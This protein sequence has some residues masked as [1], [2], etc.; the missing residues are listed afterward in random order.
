MVESDVGKPSYA[1]G[2]ARLDYRFDDATSASLHVL[3]A[4]DRS[5]LR[6]GEDVES[7]NADYRNGY[8]WGT[9]D[10]EWT[11]ALRSTLLLSYS[12][13]A[14]R[15]TGAV[16][17][18]GRRTGFVDDDRD[19]H[20]F[21][22]K[23]D[24]SWTGTRWF[25]R[26]GL[27]FRS[28]SARYRYASEV[29]FAPD[30]PFPGDPGGT[31]TR[32]L[33]PAPDGEHVAAYATSRLRVTDRLIAEAGV[34]WDEQTYGASADDQFVPRVNL[35]FDAT[36]TTRLRASWG[37]YQQAQSIN[38]LQVEDG[39]T[40]FQPTQRADMF[41]LGL[42]QALPNHQSLRIE[43]YRKDYKVLRPRYENLLDPL[44]LLPSCAGI[45]CELRQARRGPRGSRFCCRASRR[46]R[47][48]AGSAM[49]GHRSKTA[50]AGRTHAAGGTR[51]IP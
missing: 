35:A 47:G 25:H 29:T 30:Y 17:D 50:R 4:T 13:V 20:V 42:E 24:G 15:R 31:T 44:S 32:N 14:A 39:V 28:L 11:P 16:D 22:A 26:A 37:E 5:S 27:E 10:R 33:L 40:E 43:A 49:R 3:L 45:V 9:L 6:D 34:R 21:G 23:L 36:A 19:Y 48:T 8:F 41:V 51:G 18:P 12:D 38:E 46:R 1:D 2:F 7:A